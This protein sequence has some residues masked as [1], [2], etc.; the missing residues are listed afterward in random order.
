MGLV[1]IGSGMVEMPLM[2]SPNL[3]AHVFE[4]KG[5]KIQKHIP[6]WGS[7]HKIKRRRIL[8][9]L[10]EVMDYLSNTCIIKEPHNYG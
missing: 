8:R 7:E 2:E 1:V 9:D 4:S 3:V 10:D 5:N 6:K